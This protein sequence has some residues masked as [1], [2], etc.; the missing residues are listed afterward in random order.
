MAESLKNKTLK[1]FAWSALQRFSVQGVQFVVMLII[2]KILGPRAF[3]LMGMLSI[4]IAISQSFVDSGFSQ[5]LVRKQD[6]TETDNCTVFYFN[7]VVSVFM[8]AIL[9]AIAPWVAAFYKEPQ[10]ISLLRVIGLV[11]IIN[12]FAVVQRSIYTAS[13]DFKTLAK[14]SFTSAMISGAVGVYLAYS[15]FGVWTLVWQ[16]LVRTS[17]GAILLWWYSSWRPKLIYSWQSF[18]SLFAFGSN[19]LLSGLLNTLYGNIYQITIGKLFSAESL[20]Y[21]SQAKNIARLPSSN[22]N[23]IIGNVTYPVLSTIQNEDERLAINYR[24]LLRVSAF[25][26][27]P[28][29]CGLAGVSTPLID[30]FLGEQWH[31]A[32]V[33]LIPISLNMMWYPI[34]AI[35]LN[36]LKVKGRSDLFLRLE[37]LKKILGV[38]VLLVTTSFGVLVMCYGSILTGILALFINTYYTGKLIHV[39]FIRQMRDISSVL[40]TSLS[41]LLLVYFVIQIFSNSLLQ[42]IVGIVLGATYFALIC[43][44]FKFEEIDYLKSLVK[45]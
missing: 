39:G 38:M 2:A 21:F 7:I 36:L 6:R 30:V 37:I 45:K 8:Y 29:M 13:I 42:L 20:G 10:L 16:Q 5:A 3:G 31:F 18:R 34:H 4:F 12:S 15:G 11:V 19:L 28:L 23:D 43:F 25:V 1:G 44:L 35:N 17:V 33:L 27:F 40:I 22:I 26:V 14:T 41:M 9:Y 24:K 32:A